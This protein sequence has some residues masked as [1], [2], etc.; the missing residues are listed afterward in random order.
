MCGFGCELTSVSRSAMECQWQC[1]PFTVT[2]TGSKGSWK[3][4]AHDFLLRGRWPASSASILNGFSCVLP[5]YRAKLLPGLFS[6]P[7][8]A[9]VAFGVQK[10]N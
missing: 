7:V 9:H 4:T 5:L 8:I 6:Q 3:T 1:P 10:P 2:R